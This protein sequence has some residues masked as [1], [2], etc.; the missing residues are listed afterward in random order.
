VKKAKVWIAIVTCLA[1]VPM[2]SHMAAIK[3]FASPLLFWQLRW[4]C[5][6]HVAG[7]AAREVDVWALLRRLASA[8]LRAQSTDTNIAEQRNLFFIS[9]VGGLLL[10]VRGIDLSLTLNC[11]PRPHH[12]PDLEG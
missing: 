11:Q 6:R 9:L 12:L 3:S 1:T 4:C 7:K 8:S 10:V 5:R 2:V